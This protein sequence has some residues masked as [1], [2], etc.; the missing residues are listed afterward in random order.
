[1]RSV[2]VNRGDFETTVGKL[3]LLEPN[4]LSQL[5]PALLVLHQLLT[6]HLLPTDRYG[7]H[8]RSNVE[9]TFYFCA[10]YDLGFL[11]RELPGVKLESVDAFQL[12]PEAGN[13]SEQTGHAIVNA[14][15][16]L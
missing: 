14:L 8:R 12:C 5:Q 2:N 13:A 4:L 9:L 11:D 16:H 3:L 15:T 6:Q 7:A 10:D 1:M